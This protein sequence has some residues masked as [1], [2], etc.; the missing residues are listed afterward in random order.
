MRNVSE[1]INEIIPPSDYQHRNGFTNDHIID[2]LNEDEKKEVEVIL[3][4]QL[5]NSNDQLIGDT[6]A[7]MKSK[8]SLPIL[9]TKLDLSDDSSSRIYWASYILRITDDDAVRMKDIAFEE[10][11]KVTD[12][13][14]LISL[15]HT[16]IEFNDQR[17]DNRIKE[18]QDH[19]D[20]LVAYNSRTALGQ[21]TISLV[22]KERAKNKPWWKWFW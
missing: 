17:I 1:L 13:Y 10:F 11:Q 7:Y 20:Y 19:S 21:S 22:R 15:F 4:K 16:L 18:Y 12:N 14:A 9:N 8:T 5:E 3:I 6:L 2:S